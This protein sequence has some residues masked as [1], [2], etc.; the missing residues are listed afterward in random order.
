MNCLVIGGT[1]FIGSELC[2]QLQ[3]RGVEVSVTG[4]QLPDPD[5]LAAAQLV[6]YCAGVAHQSASDAEHEL[7]N[8]RSVLEMAASAADAGVTR[9][10]F[11]STVMAAAEGG[12]YAYWKWRCEQDLVDRYKGS[13]L[14]VLI[15][16][17]A[18]V[19]GVGVRSNLR[20]LMRA[21]Q[22]GLPM[23]PEGGG[24]SLIGLPDLCRGLC[25]LLELDPGHGKIL[26]MTDGEEYDLHRI[27]RSIRRG[28]G[29]STGRAW[30]PR[31]CWKMACG[32]LDLLRGNSRV[33]GSYHKLF[34]SDVYSNA[35]ACRLLHW[36]PRDTLDDLMPAMLAGLK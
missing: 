15:V 35:E 29:G 13:K 30:L 28:M 33:R 7:G 20:T 17:P 10:V 6:Y 3:S 21:M 34:S 31:W 27:C 11:V 25:Q 4:R 8:Y 24:R 32:L 36:Q 14:S 16:R 1:G 12:A 19:Y 5:Q 18:L 2:R 23:P 9:F 22:W 26:Q